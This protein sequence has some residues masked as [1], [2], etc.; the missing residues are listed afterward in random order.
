MAITSLDQLVTAVTNASD[1]MYHKS[2]IASQLAGGWS[3]Y[4]RGT[5]S[6]AQGVQPTSFD[7]CNNLTVGSIPYVGANEA[8]GEQLYLYALNFGTSVAG[9]C[10]YL[11]DRL[12]HMGG[13]SGTSATA[14][15]ANV[16]VSGTINNLPTRIGHSGYGEVLWFAEWYTATGS[17]AVT[18]MGSGDLA[19]GTTSAFQSVSLPASVA[20]SRMYQLLPP[21]NANQGFRKI[22]NV[23]LSATTGTAGNFGITAYRVIAALPPSIVANYSV[24]FDWQQLGLP[25]IPSGACL[26]YIAILSG[27]STGTFY[28]Y[29]TLV[30]G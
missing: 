26:N 28:S 22:T 16:A 19:D 21:T 17:T 23:A 29:L 27:T 25:V 30:K 2:N 5:G 20:A 11:V 18:L 6:F 1:V 10:M 9:G 8:G 12:A 4:W 15:S 7:I 24:T 13:L 3:S 14:Q